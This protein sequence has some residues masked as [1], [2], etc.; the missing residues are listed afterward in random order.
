MQRSIRVVFNGEV[1]RREQLLDLEPNAQYEVTI[2]TTEPTKP[3]DEEPPLH[4]FAALAQDLRVTDLAA[5]HVH[6]LY[7]TSKR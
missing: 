7:G 1:L 4:R 5:Q 2:E 6:Y 3:P